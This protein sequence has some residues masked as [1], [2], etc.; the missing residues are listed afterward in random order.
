MPVK[1]CQI[2]N[3]PGYKWGDQG[4]CYAHD[5]SEESKKEAKKKAVAQGVAIGDL[6]ALSTQI[7]IMTGKWKFAEEN[8]ESYTDYPEAAKN[9]AKRALD[10][11]EE[12]GWGSCGEAT[13]KQRANQ[14]AKGEPISR[15]TIARM[16]SF[17]RHQQHKDV[18]Y[19]EGCG[20][21]MWDAWGG[22]AGIE[23]AQRKLRQIDGLAEEE[24]AVE[25]TS[26][27]FDGVLATKRGQDLYKRTLGDKFVITARRNDQAPGVFKITD[28]LNI[29][30]RN[31]IF[32]G[33]NTAKVAKIKELG[34]TRHYDDNVMVTIQIP[35]IGRLF[36]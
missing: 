24:L 22:T 12:N 3:E 17:K 5:G 19:S 23:W 34:I 26:F 33:S 14:L 8:L 2:N 7:S 1:S 27:D 31:V 28:E 16:A 36:R 35:G 13:G 15:D 4:K 6:E 21:L 25:K 30:R 29:P 18:P 32:T 11:A 9:A 10:W 20:G